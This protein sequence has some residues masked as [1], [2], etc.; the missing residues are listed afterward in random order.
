M[1]LRKWMLVP[2]LALSAL[3]TGCGDDCE[4]LCE[5]GNECE[6]VEE[7]VDCG[8][9]CEDLEKLVEAAGCEDQYDD[10]LSCASDQDDVCKADDNSCEAEQTA[11]S[12]CMA[13]A[14]T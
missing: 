7:K 10:S 3:V 2:V 12:E 1:N 4:S 6:G 5:D 11:L 9:F 8:K 14:G 13:S